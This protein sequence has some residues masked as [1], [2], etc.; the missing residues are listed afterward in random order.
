MWSYWSEIQEHFIIEKEIDAVDF[1]SVFDKIPG[2]YSFEIT[3]WIKK[4]L[5]DLGFHF[6]S[7]EKL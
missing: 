7:D 5:D 6:L 2:C 1:K 4:N 3:I